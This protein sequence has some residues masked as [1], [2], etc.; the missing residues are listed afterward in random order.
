MTPN[1]IFDIDAENIAQ[2]QNEYEATDMQVKAA[3]NRAITRT[4]QTMRSRVARLVG[5]EL[6]AKSLKQIRRRLQSYRITHSP[7]Q[8]DGLKL[9]FGLDDLQ[10]GKLKGESKS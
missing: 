10:L 4:L 8:M 1:L 9:W 7:G 5:N 3:Y 6:A 2:L